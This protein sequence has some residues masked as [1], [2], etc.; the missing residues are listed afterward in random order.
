MSRLFALLFAVTLSLCFAQVRTLGQ[1]GA[2]HLW[3]VNVSGQLGDGTLIERD[4]PITLARR[5]AAVIQISAG[6]KH[7]LA[8]TATGRV[9]SWGD[10][11]YGQLGD[12]TTTDHNTPI[13][14]PGLTHVVQVAACS[15]YS[16]ALK[17]DGTVWGWGFNYYGQLGDGTSV[18]R[19]I[20]TV[21]P[22]LRGIVQVA[23]NQGT[24]VAL[25]S[26]GT[27]YSW[28]FNYYG[29]VGDG[30]TT[31][32]LSP[33][34]LPAF[35]HVVQVSEGG[36]FA[37]ALKSDGTVWAWGRNN[38]GQIGDGTTA[39]RHAPV[40]VPAV[41][42]ITQI[43]AGQEY[44]LAIQGD[45]SVMAW[46]Q[47]FAGQLGDGTTTARLSPVPI[48]GL[49]NITQVSAGNLDSMALQSDGTVLTWGANF[50]G[51]L[52]DGTTTSRNIPGVV[53]GLTNQNA[54][55]MGWFHAAS[56]QAERQPTVLTTPNFA[57]NYAQAFNMKALLRNAR[58]GAPIAG[59]SITYFIDG[60]VAAVATTDAAGRIT[61]PHPASST[62]LVGV[63]AIT[64]K[65]YGDASFIE[66]GG[67]ATLTINKADT[68]LRMN[69]FAGAVGTTRNLTATLRR[70]TDS[71]L[72][73]FKEVVFYLEGS[74][75]GSAITDGTGRAVLPYLITDAF[76]FGAKTLIAKFYGDSAHNES[77]ATSTLT[78]NQAPT[79]LRLYSASGRIG[80]NV[81]LR[82]KLS[83]TT[84]GAFLSGETVRF[85]V[86]GVAVGSG[87]TDAGG[88]A[89]LLYTPPIGSTTGVHTVSVFFDGDTDYLS[90]TASGA[91]LTVRP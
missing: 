85:E 74:P 86:D 61:V 76:G 34:A 82:A 37:M 12:G 46:G 33:T 28:G 5:P 70:V 44:A 81:L 20:P 4:S 53:P 50:T 3:G 89:I 88:V 71:A 52:G 26:D 16:L 8:L 60:T 29:M 77:S 75:I 24:T 13:V 79:R 41:A 47:N 32:R 6:D 87:V 64:A 17:S 27:V 19:L 51:V 22:S 43:S 66:S 31:N 65:F 83:R 35:D 69:N 40:V 80:S 48:P 63:H 23:S 42:G 21:S 59:K 7:T 25:K 38:A 45:G 72:L 18:S 10:N 9:Y 58:T 39:D 56:V 30:T 14:V 54:I 2:P 62:V 84:D 11:L 91:V 55:S 68:R 1:I 15:G 90:C 67:T 73:S 49:A 78:I 36:Y 57:I